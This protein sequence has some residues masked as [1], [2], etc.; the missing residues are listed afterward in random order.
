MPLDCQKK[1]AKVG[2]FSL[3]GLVPQDHLLRKIG[4]A[5]D[6]THIAKYICICYN[7]E[8]QREAD[9]MPCKRRKAPVI[10]AL[11]LFYS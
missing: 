3:E 11:R 8:K 2:F 10:A 1:S 6:F 9:M 7:V 5:V 4:S